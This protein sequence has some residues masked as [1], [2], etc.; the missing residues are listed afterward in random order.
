M[1]GAWGPAI[2][3][4]QGSL[5]QLRFHLFSFLIYHRAL[6][7]STDGP[8]QKYPTIIVYHPTNGHNFSIVTFAGFIGAITGYSSA[9]I[10]LSQK[11]WINYNGSS[12]RSGI[13]F[14]FLLRDILQ[15]DSDTDSALSRIAR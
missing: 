1:M 6:D 12:I 10:G 9:P 11:V 14:H 13:P 2:A 8:F 5:F 3:N 15:F 4:T 7:W